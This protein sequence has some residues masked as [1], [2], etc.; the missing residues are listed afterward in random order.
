[1]NTI[2]ARTTRLKDVKHLLTFGTKLTAEEVATLQEDERLL[3]DF[4]GPDGPLVGTPCTVVSGSDEYAAEVVYV[5]D[6]AHVVKVNTRR[7]EGLKFTK[8]S[9]AYRKV[10]MTSVYLRFFEATTNLDPS[11]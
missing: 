6:E 7:R 1:M 11:F 10:S 2:E 3:E 5:S 9:D 8:H 4:G